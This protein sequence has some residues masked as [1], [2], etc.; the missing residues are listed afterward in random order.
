MDRKVAVRIGTDI[1]AVGL[2]DAFG[3]GHAVACHDRSA[4]HV[5]AL[6]NRVVVRRHRLDGLC[7]DDL[8]IGEVA[9]ERGKEERED[10]DERCEALA[11]GN[12]SEDARLS[13][14]ELEAATGMAALHDGRGMC[15]IAVDDRRLGRRERCHLLLASCRLVAA[16]EKKADSDEAGEEGRA[17]L[18]HERQRHA[19][20]G[21]ELRDAGDNQECLERDGRRKADCHESCDI[22]LCTCCRGIAADCKEHEGDEDGGS[23]KQ[24]HLLADGREDEVGLDDRHVVGKTAADAG[25]HQAAVGKRVERLHDLVA[26]ALRIRPGVEPDG[27]TDLDMVEEVVAEDRADCEQHERDEDEGEASCRHIEHDD[28]DY[29]EEKGAAEVALEDDD[30]KAESPHRKDRG[31]HPWLG[32]GQRSELARGGGEKLPVL[33]QVAGKEDDKQDLCDLARLEREAAEFD[34]ELG[35]IVLRADDHGQE[36]Q[37]DACDAEGELV[38]GEIVDALHEEEDQDHGDDGE[39]EPDDLS[40]RCIRRQALHERYAYAR[41]QEDDRQD[42]RV[43]AWSE[44]PH[45]DMSDGKGSEEADGDGERACRELGSRVHDIHRIDEGDRYRSCDEKKQL[46]RAAAAALFAPLV[47]H[48]YSPCPS[49]VLLCAVSVV[50]VSWDAFVSADVLSCVVSVVEDFTSEATAAALVFSASICSW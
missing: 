3:Q 16:L 35:S 14:L 31:K 28:K 10:R 27:D 44:L 32:E 36:Q 12:T 48:G 40:C 33:C 15:R 20:H 5:R 18:A 49:C 19:R 13:R 42:H 43:C 23:T 26:R 22:G 6:C 37:D 39:E 41:K 8:D 47:C 29:E 7:L 11:E 34:P 25:A 4:L 30:K 45:G 1:G 17:A 24:A 9:D 50:D 21:Q 46:G 38:L 2:L